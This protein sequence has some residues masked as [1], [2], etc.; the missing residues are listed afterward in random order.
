[1]PAAVESRPPT[2]PPADVAGLERDASAAHLALVAEAS[3]DDAGLLASL[4]ASEAG[5]AQIVGV[6][7][8]TAASPRAS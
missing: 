5:H 7:R 2:T 6:L 1:T 8:R 4:A 3:G